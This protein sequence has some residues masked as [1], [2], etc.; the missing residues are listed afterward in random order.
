M[1]MAAFGM[2]WALSRCLGAV[3]MPSEGGPYGVFGTYG[4]EDARRSSIF[5]V[6]IKD[7]ATGRFAHNQ[8][9]G[10]KTMT[11]QYRK[12]ANAKLDTLHA[13]I[14]TLKPRLD[15]HRRTLEALQD[16]RHKVAERAEKAAQ[17]RPPEGLGEVLRAISDA[18]SAL[19]DVQNEYDT[20]SERANY[21]VALLDADNALAKAQAREVSAR[22]SR[23][24]L[25]ARIAGL[26]SAVEAGIANVANAQA[27]ADQARKSKAAALAAK[28]TGTTDT[29]TTAD[30]APHDA[31]VAE[32]SSAVEMLKGQIADLREQLEQAD[33]NLTAAKNEADR[34][35]EMVARGDY[36]CAL[37]VFLPVAYAYRRSGQYVSIRLDDAFRSYEQEQA[38]AAKRASE[39]DE[40]T[41]EV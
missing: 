17:W 10:R 7:F 26:E 13:R 15:K 19:Q 35:R 3:P 30:P 39:H 29:P 38:H 6:K 37:S 31:A 9:K 4:A 34:A 33:A 20:A 22:E 23:D 36:E 1:N 41:I 14:A 8:V 28:L 11:P 40:E 32:W 25:A 12:S 2:P 21:L 27:A 16:K 24:D 5:A 18:D